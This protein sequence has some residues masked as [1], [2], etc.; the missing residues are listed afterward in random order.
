MELWFYSVTSEEKGAPRVIVT[1][2]AAVVLVWHQQWHGVDTVMGSDYS[3]AWC[4]AQDWRQG[5][6]GAKQNLDGAEAGKLG[7][8]I[9]FRIS[10]FK[11]RIPH[12]HFGN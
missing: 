6:I 9:R 1:Q 3:N 11:F 5:N 2:V 8:F 4:G 7:K 10:K 12:F